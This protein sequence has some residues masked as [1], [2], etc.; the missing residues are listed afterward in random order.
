MRGIFKQL[1]NDL[2]MITTYH[3]FFTLEI[4]V[5]CTKEKEEGWSFYRILHIIRGLFNRGRD[6]TYCHK[7][8]E[9]AT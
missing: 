2:S 3:C 4:K 6:E 9:G 5:F 7:G 8:T 1:I